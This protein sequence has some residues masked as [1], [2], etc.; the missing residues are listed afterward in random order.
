MI[1]RISLIENNTL[2]ALRSCETL[3]RLTFTLLDGSRRGNEWKPF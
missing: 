1:Y 3:D 2:S